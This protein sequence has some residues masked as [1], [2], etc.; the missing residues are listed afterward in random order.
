MPACLLADQ[1]YPRRYEATETT[2]AIGRAPAAKDNKFPLLAKYQ[3]SQIH[4][5]VPSS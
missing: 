1:V 2:D 3:A 5:S 4:A